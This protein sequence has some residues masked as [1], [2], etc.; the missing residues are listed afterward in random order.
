MAR[1]TFFRIAAIGFA[2]TAAY[3]DETISNYTVS[4]GQSRIIIDNGRIATSDTSPVTVQNMGS[5]IL[6]SGGGIDLKPGFH[7][8]AGSF[9]W[10]AVDSNMNGYSDVEE[11]TDSDGDGMCDAWEIDHGLNPFD[12]TDAAKDRDG[13]GISNLAESRVG[14]RAVASGTDADHDGISDYVEYMLGTN[15]NIPASAPSATNDAVIKL[16]IHTP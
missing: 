7:A 8:V 16:N 14:S 3:A 1:R 5:L 12:P 4:S 15:P 13:D 2:F 11:A 6:W 10:A 9:F